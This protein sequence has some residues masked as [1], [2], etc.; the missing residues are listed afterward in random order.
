MKSFVKLVAIG[1]CLVL[2]MSAVG[3]GK[4]Q[5][6]GSPELSAEERARR[7]A[8]ARRQAELE[9]LRQRDMDAQRARELGAGGTVKNALTEM[10]FFAYDSSEI[11]PAAREILQ[12]KANALKAQPAV[13]LTVEGYCDERGTPEYNMALGQRRAKS[14]K[15]YLTLLGVSAARL[16]TVSYGEE[17][18]LAT[19]QNEAAWA[20]N[21][22]AEF[23]P[24]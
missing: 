20:K 19:G 22:R 12:L 2:A 4:K 13:R 18:P 21:R 7:E 16:T 11:S 5:V 6:S 15:E 10:I 23:K 1:L 14:A 17:R 9:A 24:N 3:C 8:E